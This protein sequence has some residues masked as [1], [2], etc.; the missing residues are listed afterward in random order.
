MLDLHT[1]TP[2]APIQY[3]LVAGAFGALRAH[4]IH[5]SERAAWTLSGVPA[6]GAPRGR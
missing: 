5:R 3:R 4:R 6:P 2:R 1:R